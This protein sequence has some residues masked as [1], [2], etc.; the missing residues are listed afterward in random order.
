MMTASQHLN[1]GI[2]LFEQAKYD[3]A[4]SKLTQAL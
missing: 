1:E 3:Q 4:I 2:E